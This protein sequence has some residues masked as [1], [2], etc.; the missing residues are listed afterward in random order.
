METEETK[1]TWGGAR[2]GAGRKKTGNVSVFFR[3]PADLIALLDG[4]GNKS[5]FVAEA[6]RHYAEAKGITIPA[7]AEN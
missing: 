1:T 2:K 6:I 4:V 3:L 7:A 5:A